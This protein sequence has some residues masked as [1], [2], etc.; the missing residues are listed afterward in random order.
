MYFQE[1]PTII[2]D[3]VGDGNFKDVKNLLRRV[4]LR[5]AVRTNI[6]LYDTYDVKEGETPEI[7]A[8]KLY[9]DPELHWVILM[10]N[11]VTDRF[12]QWPLSTPQFLDFIN[13][14][15]SNPDGIHHYEVPQSSG[16]TK[17]K[18]EIFNE[19]DED[20]YTG[21]TPITNREY[22]ENRQDDIRQIRLIDPT[23]V[24]QFV[25]EFKTSMKET[26]I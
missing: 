5:V 6:L 23:Y 3:S 18:I 19:V 9:G 24:G 10:I 12:H 1:F 15:Y 26:A 16:N 25:S 20:A 8:S 13:D 4:G 2:Y 17:T 22:E 11:N 7:I 21:L 14:K